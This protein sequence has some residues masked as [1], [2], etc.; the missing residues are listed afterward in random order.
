MKTI[1][2]LLSHSGSLF[3]KAINIYTGDLYTHVSIALDRDLK[4]L[5]SF[6]RIKPYNPII[7]GFVK[8]DIENGTFRRF[9]NTRCALYSL[10]ITDEQY[11]RLK[12]ELERFKKERDKYGYNF[13]GVVSAAFNYPIKREYKYFCSQFVSELLLKSGIKIIDKNPSLTAPMDFAKSDQLECIY[14]GY[15]RYYHGEG[16][17]ILSN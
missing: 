9:P 8:E 2:I 1:Y 12:A 15:L 17:S 4:E 3:S 5:Y 16:L 13:L 10:K 14:E 11:N 7:G 6:G